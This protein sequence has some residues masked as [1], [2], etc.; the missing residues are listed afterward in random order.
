M[1]LIVLRP[2]SLSHFSISLQLTTLCQVSTG[3]DHGFT[4]SGEKQTLHCKGVILPIKFNKQKE[5]PNQYLL[6]CLLHNFNPDHV[7]FTGIIGINVTIFKV[8]Q[9]SEIAKHDPLD[10]IQVTTALKIL[11]CS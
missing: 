1:Q 2:G 4:W 9:E 6:Y 7:I 10:I 8:I 11:V 3:A 5:N